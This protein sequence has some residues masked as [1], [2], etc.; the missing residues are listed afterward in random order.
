MKEVKGIE[1]VK[2]DQKERKLQSRDKLRVEKGPL[3]LRKEQNVWEKESR[4]RK[5][6]AD[7]ETLHNIEKKSKT[8]SRQRQR[9]EQLKFLVQ[10]QL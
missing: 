1:A 9:R 2:K 3:T 4:K 5:M 8:L 6:D 10:H 7:P